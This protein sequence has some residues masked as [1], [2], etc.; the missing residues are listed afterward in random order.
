MAFFTWSLAV[1][2]GAT[3]DPLDQ[4]GNSWKYRYIPYD[5]IVEIIHDTTAVGVTQTITAGS[6]EILQESP[7]SAGGTAGVLQGRLN[8]E[9][10]TFKAKAGDLVIIRYRN[11]TAG[12]LTISGSI[13]LTP[14]K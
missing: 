14:G 12:A 13:E 7:V 10:V 3:S 2:A 1:A 11:T 4:A 8:R 5:C 9:P 6:D